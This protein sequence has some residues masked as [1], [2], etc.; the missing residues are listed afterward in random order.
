[1]GMY[2]LCIEAKTGENTPFYKQDTVHFHLF[3]CDANKI[4]KS[5]NLGISINMSVN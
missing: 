1:M 3:L 2:M 4:C 5:A